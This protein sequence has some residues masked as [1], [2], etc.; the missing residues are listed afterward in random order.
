[1]KFEDD[2][3]VNIVECVVMPI[4]WI[5]DIYINPSNNGNLQ[6]AKYK[7]VKSA[8]KRTNKEFID[9][10]EKEIENAKVKK[11]KKK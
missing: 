6:S 9:L 2:M 8:I 11:L 10:L 4:G 7:D 3:T 1:M 5:P